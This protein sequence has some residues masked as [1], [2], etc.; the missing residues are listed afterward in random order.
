MSMTGSRRVAINVVRCSFITTTAWTL[1]VAT[2]GWVLLDCTLWMIP[3]I[4][5]AS[6]R[7]VRPASGNR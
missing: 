3:P 7:R 2:C 4:L 5:D 6:L 1:P